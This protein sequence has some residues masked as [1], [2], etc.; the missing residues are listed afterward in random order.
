MTRLEIDPIT[1]RS[2]GRRSTSYLVSIYKSIAGHYRPVRV[3]DRPITA[4]YS[5]IKNASWVGHFDRS[6]T[7]LTANAPKA[8]LRVRFTKCDSFFG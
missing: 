6:W 3:A 4:R 2:E 1:S 7:L 8:Q 5:F